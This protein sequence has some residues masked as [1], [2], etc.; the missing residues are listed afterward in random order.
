MMDVGT[1]G[2]PRKGSRN[3]DG[4]RQ[5]ELTGQ[6]GS[7]QKTGTVSNMSYNKSAKYSTQAPSS[8]SGQ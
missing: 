1:K 3:T 5:N 4:K 8:N 6:L 7:S 2:G